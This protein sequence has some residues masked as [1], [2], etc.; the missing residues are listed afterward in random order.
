MSWFV[1]S[2]VRQALIVGQPANEVG[3][4]E[5]VL[6]ISSSSSVT[7]VGLQQLDALVN[8]IWPLRAAVAGQRDGV[9]ANRLRYL[10]PGKP[11]NPAAA[12][13]IFWSRTSAR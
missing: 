8:R 10:S 12:T 6:N 7:S 3:A 9:K 4:L 2:A 1:A 13:A 11:V 5:R